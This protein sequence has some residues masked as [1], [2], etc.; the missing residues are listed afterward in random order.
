MT[1]TANVSP[2]AVTDWVE[3]YLTAWSSAASNDIKALFTPAAEY[4]ERPYET[5]WI[6]RE[7]IVEG[8]LSRQEWQEGG[9]TFDWEIL[10][11]TGDTAAIRGTGV[12]KE[13][14]TFENL[15]VVTL[16]AKGRCSTFRMWNNQV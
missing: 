1:T 8:W 7:A 12:Y 4:H 2:A 13:L 9:W 3:R 10:M 11:I 16:D 6:G 5:E 15:W 14:G